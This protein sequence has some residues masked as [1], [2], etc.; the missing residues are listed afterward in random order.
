MV[1]DFY[2][3]VWSAT[4]VTA[5]ILVASG[6][7]AGDEPVQSPNP[8]AAAPAEGAA[9][10]PAPPEPGAADG[11]SAAPAEGTAAAAAPA[12]ETPTFTPAAPQAKG[13]FDDL[14]LSQLLEVSV[15]ASK[16]A[17]SIA[18]APSSITVFTAE[19]NAALGLK[20]LND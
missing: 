13:E 1:R 8:E 20:N 12:A 19:K 15:V 3:Y 10:V 5:G 14:S 6:T 7:A 18:D 17:E 4:I 2:R 9:S 11:I 16:R